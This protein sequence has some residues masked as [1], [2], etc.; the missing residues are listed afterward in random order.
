MTEPEREAPE[1]GPGPLARALLLAW[2]A[3]VAAI[4]LVQS[5]AAGDLPEGGLR[6]GLLE[7]QRQLRPW[8]RR[9]RTVGD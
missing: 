8:L 1:A 6:D 9:E 4:A 3:A 5:T 2:I 7:A